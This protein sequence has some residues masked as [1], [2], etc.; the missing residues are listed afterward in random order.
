MGHH[1]LSTS[2]FCLS[3]CYS[4]QLALSLFQ[5][6]LQRCSF[7]FFPFQ[8]A[9]SFFKFI[10]HDTSCRPR[11]NIWGMMNFQLVFFFC[12]SC[13]YSYELA[14]SLFQ[15]N[16]QRLQKERISTH[17]SVLTCKPPLQHYHHTKQL[18]TQS[19]RALTLLLPSQTISLSE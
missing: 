9:I 8:Q 17:F 11:C 3:C 6:N 10:L 19:S 2:F 7:I 4:Y 5:A 13:C 15:A 14:L 12:L 18:H 16:L 1:V